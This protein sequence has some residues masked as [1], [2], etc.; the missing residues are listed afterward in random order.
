MFII[1]ITIFAGAS[2]WAGLSPNATSLIIARAVQGIGGAI[3]VPGS[4]ALIGA[5]FSDSGQENVPPSR[6]FAK[7]QSPLPSQ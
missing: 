1:G 3:F 5:C 2:I 7:R 6:R 4:L